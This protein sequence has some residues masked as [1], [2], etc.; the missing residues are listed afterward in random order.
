MFTMHFNCTT[1][2]SSECL[3]KNCSLKKLTNTVAMN[4][5]KWQITNRNAIAMRSDMMAVSISQAVLA[6]CSHYDIHI[7]VYPML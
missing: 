4:S 3:R 5:P 6:V 1:H 7:Q 2:M